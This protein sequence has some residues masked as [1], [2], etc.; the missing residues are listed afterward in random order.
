MTSRDDRDVTSFFVDVKNS[1]V[2]IDDVC[3][4][5]GIVCSVCC[6]VFVHQQQ[7]QHLLPR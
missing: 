5:T 7:Q 4:D 2:V 6:F 3:E 1:V